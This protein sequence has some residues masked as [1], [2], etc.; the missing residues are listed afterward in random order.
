MKKYK[1]EDLT[2]G[3]LIE[4]MKT[5]LASPNQREL[6]FIMADRMGK[7]AETINRDARKAFDRSN[8]R[9][10]FQKAEA[11]QERGWELQ[12]R[13]HELWK[14]AMTLPHFE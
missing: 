6:C 5:K 1:A 11:M 3:E 12:E 14:H 13:S 9:E 10:T 2:K 7:R 8:S 4:H